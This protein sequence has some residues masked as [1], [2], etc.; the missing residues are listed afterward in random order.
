M[1]Q[2]D[3]DSLEY[4]LWCAKIHVVDLLTQLRDERGAADGSCLASC[5]KRKPRH[6]GNRSVMREYRANTE[7]LKS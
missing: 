7:S 6:K 1:D 2:V 5:R 3:N 4:V